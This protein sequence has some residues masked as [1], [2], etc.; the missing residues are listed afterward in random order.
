MNNLNVILSVVSVVIFVT[1]TVPGFL[2][3]TGIRKNKKLNVV[4]MALGLLLA[5]QLTLMVVNALMG[6]CECGMGMACKCGKGKRCRCPKGGR[7][8]CH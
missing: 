4:C 7:C 5:V 6:T 8:G 2:H 1:C 3:I